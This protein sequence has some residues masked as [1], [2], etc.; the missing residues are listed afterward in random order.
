M[1][2]PPQ[3]IVPLVRYVAAC[4]P[5][6]I[7]A[8][9]DI[10]T[11]L[12]ARTPG[13]TSSRSRTRPRPYH[14]WNERITRECYAPQ[15]P[16]PTP[17]RAG[18]DHQ[19]AEQLR[20]DELQ[21]R[22]DA[23]LLDGRLRP[24]RA[25]RDRRGRSPQSRAAR[26]PRQ[27]P[28]AGV[29]PHDHA[30]GQRAR[31]ADAGALGHRRLPLP[32]RPR[33]PRGCGWPRR[34]WTSPRSRRWP[35]RA[36]ASPSWP[37]TRPNAGGGS[38]TTEWHEIPGGIDPSR[39][40]LCELPSGRSIALFF[41]DGIIS[42]QVAFERLLDNGEAFL[43]RLLQGFDD[44][45]GTR[46]SC[47]SPPTASRTATTTPTATWP[48][49]TCSTRLSL[50]PEIR[51]TNYGEF[52]ELHPPE[53]EVEIHEK[54][55]WSCAHG[56]ERWNSDCGCKTRGDWHQQ[57]AR[58]APAGVRPAQGP[59]RPPVQ[60]PGPRVLPRPLGGPRRLHRRHPRTAARKSVR[61]FLRQHG[62]PDLDDEQIRDAL[63]LLEMQRNG[64]LMYTSCGWFFDEISGLET[65]QC[66]HYAARAIHLA[67][68]FQPR[69][70]EEV[71]PDAQDGAEQPAAVQDRPGGLGAVDPPR[72]W[73][74][75]TASWRTTPISLIFPTREPS[76]R[77]VLVRPRGPR[78]GGPQPGQQP[79]G[80][81][82]GSASARDQTWD[83][84]ETAFVVIHYGGLDF[85]TVLRHVA[86]PKEYEGLKRR[87]M[88]AYKTGSLADVTEPGGARVRGARSTGSTTSSSTSSGGSSASSCQDRIEDYQRTFERLVT[89]D[90][91][92]LN[93]LGQM[94]YPIPKP[95]RA[96]ALV[97]PRPQALARSSPG[98][99][100][101]ATWRAI[102]APLRA[103]QD[104]GLSARA[105]AARESALGGP[106]A[107]PRRSRPGGRPAR[108]GRPREPAPR[109]GRAARDLRSTSGG[110][111][112]SC[113]TPTSELADSGA[114]TEPLRS[115]FANLAVKLNLSQDLLGWRALSCRI[116]VGSSSVT[117]EPGS[118]VESAPI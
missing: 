70:R 114:M 82:A 20:L 59:A 29:Q 104:L 52:L 64:M 85:H 7:F 66:L 1:P 98:W 8:S 9:T 63:R 5:R 54:S 87:L 80:R 41:Y 38:A 42:R 67:R 92:V 77:L 109:R 50:D 96:A 26:R 19:P 90:D 10:S 61:H 89:Q 39:A 13:S 113:S 103:G 97:V 74:T 108:A 107:D 71:R 47:T 6:A 102:Q 31:Q 73:S 11:S 36:S 76:A 116:F 27:R 55:A 33:C 49:R 56:V 16:V 91:D 18:Q 110:C 2:G 40:Y 57:V 83:E 65:T 30:A 101:T 3:R 21:L 111:R 78:P 22:A 60:H 94:H 43:E 28:G 68:H 37:R 105:R 35:R 88:D 106:G 58:A 100:S 24:G 81:R 17:R 84:A 93:R 51:L 25:A 14:D 12:P 44:R 79:P 118:T 15:H 23:P 62:H 4:T 75:S 34:R 32:L 117:G 95:L 99:R 112:T 86:S 48:W 69:L 115:V 72:R 53:W 46:S 45:R